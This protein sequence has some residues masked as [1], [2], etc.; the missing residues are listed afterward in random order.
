MASEI[1][2]FGSSATFTPTK[3]LSVLKDDDRGPF[4]RFSGF[5]F[6]AMTMSRD[7]L[8]DGEMHPDGDEIVYVAS[9]RIEV[10]FEG[11]SELPVQVNA[12]EGVIIP[13]GIW[14]KVRVLELGELVTISQGQASNFVQYRSNFPASTGHVD[15]TSWSRKRAE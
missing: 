1:T 4:N 2:K 9:G 13:K 11:R 5:T 10:A 12:G 7:E 15:Q 14:H 6:S 3:D 8:H